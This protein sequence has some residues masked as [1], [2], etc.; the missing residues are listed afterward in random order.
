MTVMKADGKSESVKVPDPKTAQ[1]SDKAADAAEEHKPENAFSDENL[2]KDTVVEG[3]SLSIGKN[4][5]VV[6]APRDKADFIDAVVNN[7]RY[8]RDY[9]LFG[10]KILLTLRTLTVDETNALATWTAK[11]GTRD[12]AGLMAGRYRK[13]LVA[14]MVSKYN[15]VEM[16]PLEAPL[17]ETLGDDGKTV[18]PPGW[19]NRCNFWDGTAVG[20]F[21]A[22]MQCIA[23]FDA[24]YAALCAKADDANFWN[25][26]TP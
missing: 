19:L 24:L 12:S 20:V 25:P 18:N 17:F 3:E 26:D 23:H 13:Y 8:T 10:G 9:S 14:A 21:S 4:G 1:N 6:I 5:K 16:P 15:G 22:I 2:P 11:V 7:V